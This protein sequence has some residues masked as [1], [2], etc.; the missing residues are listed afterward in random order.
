M[1]IPPTTAVMVFASTNSNTNWWIDR[2]WRID[3]IDP[4]ILFIFILFLIEPL[5][6]SVGSAGPE[7]VLNTKPFRT[8]Q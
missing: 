6:I 3:M 1:L 5:N 4:S 7:G 8:K 2:T